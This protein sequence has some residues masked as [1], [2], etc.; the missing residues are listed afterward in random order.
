MAYLGFSP[1]DGETRTA[2]ASDV[3]LFSPTELRVIGLAERIDATREIAHHSRLGRFAEWALGVRLGRPL[4]DPRLESLRRF[5]S[6]A[7]HHADQL[8]AEDVTRLVAAG[9]SRRQAQGLLSYL[10]G[11]R[12]DRTA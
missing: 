5:T 4:A 8:G 1:L 2:T 10:T 9:Y 11:C 7:R 12:H 6:M 3:G